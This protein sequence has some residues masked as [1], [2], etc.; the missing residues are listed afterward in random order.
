MEKICDFDKCTACN[1]CRVACPKQCIT[2]QNDKLLVPHPFI[3]KDKCIDCGLCKKVCPVNNALDLKKSIKVYAAWSNDDTIRGNSASGGIATEI[4][5]YFLDNVQNSYLL[6]ACFNSN[7]EVEYVPIESFEQLLKIQNSKYVYSNTLNIYSEIK[8]KLK[9]NF[10]VLFVG[11]PCQVAGLK[12]Y[13]RK[14]YSN[15]LTI[16][17]VC[18]GVAPSDYLKQ[19]I[20]SIQNKIKKPVNQISFRDPL[21]LTYTY[22]FTLRNEGK[23]YYKKRVY[24]DDVYQLGYHKALIYRENCYHCQYAQRSRVSDLTLCDFSGVGKYET[25]NYSKNNVSCILVNTEKGEELLNLI[26]SHITLIERPMKEAYDFESQLNRP[27]DPH[28]K[29]DNFVKLLAKTSD[30]EYAASKALQYDIFH[31]RFQKTFIGKVLCFFFKIIIK[32]KNVIKNKINY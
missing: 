9:S 16:D 28:P 24:E 12:G 25:F 2:M 30:F 5:K 22:T 6:G 3:D 23:V 18:H 14:E 17:L 4:Y 15:L 20:E 8:E 13:L 19:H 27:Y 21:F 10:K 1:A 29:R 32:S 7:F 31:H 26:K 11:L